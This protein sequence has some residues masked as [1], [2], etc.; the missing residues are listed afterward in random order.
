M[1]CSWIQNDKGQGLIC[2]VV[3]ANMKEA[4]DVTMAAHIHFSQHQMVPEALHLPWVLIMCNDVPWFTTHVT[5]ILLVYIVHTPRL[6]FLELAD[7]DPHSHILELKKL[8]RMHS[9]A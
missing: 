4:S 3:T 8:H 9:Y 2:T 1:G 7:P 5:K 6:F